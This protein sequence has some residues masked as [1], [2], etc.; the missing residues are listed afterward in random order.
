MSDTLTQL[1]I[2]PRRLPC[3]SG[4]HFDL[5]EWVTFTGT[6][7]TKDHKRS[8]IFFLK[9]HK[10]SIT[11]KNYSAKIIILQ[12]CRAPFLFKITFEGKIHYN[13]IKFIN[14][15]IFLVLHASF[16][17]CAPCIILLFKF[18][19][20]HFI[21]LPFWLYLKQGNEETGLLNNTV[22]NNN[23]NPSVLFW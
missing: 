9:T 8:I 23:T 3:P 15:C 20:P 12:T 1:H 22:S 16:L 13:S 17:N 21:I 19:F 6:F 4:C 10:D 5:C 7:E 14:K 11:S 18:P 2:R